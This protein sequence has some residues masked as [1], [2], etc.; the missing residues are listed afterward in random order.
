[1]YRN[2]CFRFFGFVIWSILVTLTYISCDRHVNNP[3]LSEVDT[4]LSHQQYDSAY[5]LLQQWHDTEVSPSEADE[6]YYGLLLTVSAQTEDVL[7]I[8]LHHQCKPQLLY[9]P[10]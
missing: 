4:L 7:H 2:K 8:R 6:A 3:V 1:M 9:N 10:P 5:S